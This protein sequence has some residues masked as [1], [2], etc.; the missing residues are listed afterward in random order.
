VEKLLYRSITGRNLNVQ[1]HQHFGY[2]LYL[3]LNTLHGH[4]HRRRRRSIERGYFHLHEPLNDV[5]GW[6]KCG[7]SGM[8]TCMCDICYLPEEKHKCQYTCME[9][10][11]PDKRHFLDQLWEELFCDIPA[12]DCHGDF[13]VESSQP[14]LRSSHNYMV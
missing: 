4:S 2:K 6:I 14:L 10:E 12:C 13:S 11:K 8:A 7:L 3:C 1:V 9:F 5:E